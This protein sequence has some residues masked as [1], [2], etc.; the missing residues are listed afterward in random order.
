MF[1]LAYYGL[2]EQPSSRNRWDVDHIVGIHN[3]SHGVTLCNLVVVVIHVIVVVV[4][5]VP[6]VVVV[7]GYQVDCIEGCYHHCQ[8]AKGVESTANCCSLSTTLNAC[9]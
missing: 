3:V 4:I 1:S 5:V 6:P 8:K 2:L 9:N 7:G